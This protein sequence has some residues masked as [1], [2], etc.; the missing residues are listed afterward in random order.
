MDLLGPTTFVDTRTNYPVGPWDYPAC[1]TR[2][3][4]A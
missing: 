2:H 3:L 4:M 1:A